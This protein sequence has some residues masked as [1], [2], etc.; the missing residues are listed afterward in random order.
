MA[1]V[2]DGPWTI[3]VAEGLNMNESEIADDL[4]SYGREEGKIDA[5]VAEWMQDFERELKIISDFRT[6][7]MRFLEALETE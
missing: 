1:G 6:I 4:R 3:R 2:L 5:S 7:S